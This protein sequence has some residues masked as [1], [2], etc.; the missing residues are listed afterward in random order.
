MTGDPHAGD[1]AGQHV[2]EGTGNHQAGKRPWLVIGVFDGVHAAH[3]SMI[4]HAR[5]HAHGAPLCAVTFHPH[6]RAAVTGNH[7]GL[8]CPLEERIARLATLTDLPPVVLSFD[9]RLRLMSAA[10]FV[11]D[12]LAGELHARGVTVGGNFRFGHRAEGNVAMLAELGARHD[13]QI[14]LAPLFEA[15]GE[16]VSS[17]R[18]RH[19]LRTGKI[20]AALELLGHPFALAGPVVRGAQRGRELGF[21]TANLQVAPELL[22]PADGVY[23]GVAQAEGDDQPQLAAASIGTNPHFTAQQPNPPRSV[24]AHLLDYDGDLYGRRLRVELHRLLRGQREF[25]SVAQLVDQI[26][27][28]VQLVRTGAWR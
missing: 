11:T 22:V 25:D 10:T 1:T 23:A 21:P 17:T 13:I 20:E 4:A 7:P 26:S 28:D 8:L 27:A 9:D 3:E 18:I 15:G 14:E 6:P 24:E 2:G 12:V 5:E 16:A 19:L